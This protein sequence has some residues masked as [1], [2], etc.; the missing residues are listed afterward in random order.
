M[1]IYK[2]IFTEDEVCSDSFPITQI[3][4]AVFKA[5]SKIATKKGDDDYG[6]AS[7]ED[8]DEAAQG[9]AGGDGGAEQVD[10]IIDS[11]KLQPVSVDKSGYMGMMKPYMAALKKK[12]EE[13]S[14]ERVKDFMDGAQ[15]FV[16]EVLAK[17]NDYEFY[18]SENEADVQM[19]IAR[20]FGEDG[21]TPYFYF[22]KDGLK[23]MKV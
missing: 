16:K 6:I 22:F 13:K 20:I 7:N 11:F 14:P 9:G 2:D 4:S 3:N 21:M 8:P 15:A 12:V 17:F 10:Q 23:E 5:E 19:V 18:R 1:I